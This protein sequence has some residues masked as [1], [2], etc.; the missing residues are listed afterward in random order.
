M[1]MD[2]ESVF[3][4]GYNAARALY[5]DGQSMKTNLVRFRETLVGH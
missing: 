1:I 5:V 3:K 2:P 4:K